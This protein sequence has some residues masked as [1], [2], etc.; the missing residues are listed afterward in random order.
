MVAV[1]MIFNEMR[2]DK[3]RIDIIG[4]GSLGLLYAGKLASSG[5][6]V[7]I[8][9]R[10][11]EQA[12]R[13]K[14]EGVHITSIE[15]EDVG[16]VSPS[17][18][19]AGVLDNIIEEWQLSPAD[20]IFL[21][22]KQKDIE[23]IG[24]QLLA[25]LDEVS[26]KG[27]QG[28]ICFQ[29]GT[30][31][32][33][34][35]NSLLPRWNIYSA[36]TTEAAKRL[37]YHE[38][39]HAGR[40]VTTI[41][42]ITHEN[43]QKNSRENEND[44]VNILK[45]AGFDCDLSNEIVNHVYRKLLINAVIN[46]LTALWKIPNG[47]LMA[48]RARVDMMRNLFLEGTEVYD[49]CGVYWDDNLWDQIVNICISTAANTSSMLK[50]VLEELPTEVKWINGSIVTMAEENGL[51]AKYHKSMVQLIEGISAKER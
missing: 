31:H 7:R 40:G 44:L 35:L 33:Q 24:S 5:N 10:S 39:F 2:M 38:V 37:S 11:Q 9:C 32:I 41:G 1:K 18:I 12:D 6:N 4:G 29:N 47:E 34:L 30:G 13:I 43:S 50:D 25:K 26:Q 46:P 42:L 36:I 15:G 8:W 20:W 16:R 14:T 23:D 48:T 21:M 27:T 22:T 49:A 3:L 28:M 19:E 51:T 45:E 17:V